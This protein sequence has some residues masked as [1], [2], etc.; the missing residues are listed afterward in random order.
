MFIAIVIPTYQREDGKTP[1]YLKRTLDCV[2]RQTHK[3][4]VVYLIGDHYEDE[5][6]LL[7]IIS[8]YPQYK[9]RFENLPVSAE[10]EKYKD[11][12][13]LWTCGGTV[14]T[15]YGI[16]K[17]REEGLQYVCLLDHD[18]YWYDNHLE[19]MSDAIKKEKADWACTKFYSVKYNCLPILN[20]AQEI[21]K[22]LPLPYGLIKA[23]VCFNMEKI[24]LV[25]R[26][27][28]EETGYAFPGDADL[29][30]RMAEHIKVNKLKSIMVNKV[31]GFHDVE[32]FAEGKEITDTSFPLERPA[33]AV[34][35][36]RASR[37]VTVIT[38]TGDRLDSFNL[39]RQ[40]MKN[41]TLQPKQWIVVD[42][43]KTP[44]P[45]TKGLPFE[46]YRREPSDKDYLHTLCLNLPVA[47][48]KVRYEKIIIM[49]DDDWYH[50]TYIDYMCSLL[51]KSDLTGFANLIFYNPTIQKYMIKGTARQ[52]AL[53]QTAFRKEII[54]VV[55]T[56]CAGAF[57]KY[58]LC[59]KGL[60]DAELWKH[61]LEIYREKVSVR[62]TTSLKISTG[63]IIAKGTEFQPPV[64]VGL[65]KRAER[66][67]GAEFVRS[68]IVDKGKKLIVRCPEYLTVGMKG[69]PGR[70]GLTSHHAVSNTKYKIDKGG[71]LLKSILKK[72]A[73]FYMKYFV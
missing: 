5:K 71:N 44:L 41:Q 8:E 10:R 16:G 28:Y 29:W 26:N 15:N 13:V 60:L 35:I 43:G 14:A 24:P 46:Y 59:G 33:P 39:L 4:F 61:S 6:E 66:R 19:I 36:D 51:D 53:A 18:D 55:E 63:Q 40:W 3:N 67:N 70:K 50:P 21:I 11:K 1:F 12:K 31:T 52:P 17:A 54:P 20:T 25:P 68:K 45:Y 64:P 65:I 32:R 62:L 48:S 49:E 42:D 38:C 47:L 7:G 57:K 22:F 58:D 37:E 73:E 23:S 2:F 9:I 72:D 30:A 27:V 69:L 34:P 56:V